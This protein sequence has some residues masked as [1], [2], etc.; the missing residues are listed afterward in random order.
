[1]CSIYHK[2]TTSVEGPLFRPIIC[3]CGSDKLDSGGIICSGSLMVRR[4]D[5]AGAMVVDMGM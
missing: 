4:K 2:F 5:L 1:M 3:L